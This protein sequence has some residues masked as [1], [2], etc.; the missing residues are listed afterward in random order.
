MTDNEYL[1]VLLKSLLHGDPAEELPEGCDFRRVF[2]LAENHSVAGMAF[3]AAEALK[4]PPKGELAAQWRQVRDKAL[5]KDITQQAELE[6]IGSAF[7]AEGVRFL[8][9][10]GCVIKHYYP[11]SD[12]RTMSDI[13][14]LIDPQNAAKARD[15]M[16]ALGYT[17]EHYDYEHHDVYY[18]PPVMNVE[19][20]RELL[21]EEGK[22]FSSVF[23]DPWSFCARNENSEGL[24]YDF[25]DNE[26]FAYVLAHAI[27]HLEEGGT[28]IRTVMDLWV[29]LHSEM[30]ID[31]ERVFSMLEPSGRAEQA[32]LLAELSEVWFGEK[33]HTE[34]TLALEQYIFGSGTYGTISNMISNDIRRTG[35]REYIF[36]LVFPTFT[37]MKRQYPVLKKAPA[38]LPFCWLA[39]LVTKPFINRRANAEKLRMLTKK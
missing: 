28:G 27:K 26:F 15:I 16:T 24:R 36:R 33:P 19:I 22:A 1:I 17:C 39:R 37:H 21:G 3:Y 5:V 34:Q 25:R 4:L 38:L 7:S 6:T 13:D 31:C 35:K 12:M 29:C 9:L 32:R 14:M 20:H 30:N 11:Q 8:P 10:K 2:E 23:P 18:K